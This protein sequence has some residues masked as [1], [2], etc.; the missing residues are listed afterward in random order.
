VIETVDLIPY[1]LPLTRPWRSARGGLGERRGW[2]IRVGSVEL[3]GYGDCAPLP[4]AGTEE[5]AVAWAWL[6][7]WRKRSLRHALGSALDDLAEASPAPGAAW[8]AG[9]APAA[10]NAAECALADLAA[11]R[12]GVPLARWLSAGAVERIPVN[13]AL[14]ALGDIVPADLLASVANGYRVLKVKV[15]LAPPGEE[16]RRLAGL[17]PHIP[18][19]VALRLDANGAWTLGQA[20]RVMAGLAGL[21]ERAMLRVESLEEPLRDPSAPDLRRL[22]AEA[23][24]PLA[25][26]ESLHRPGTDWDPTDLPVRR[27]VLKPAVIGGLRRTMALAA[28]ARAAGP[29]VVLTGLIESAAGLWPTVH[30]AAALGGTIPQGLATAHW[31]SRDLGE[32][33][34]P[35]GGWIDLP[36]GP[37]GGYCPGPDP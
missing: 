8:G 35:D 29:E 34:R 28:R 31:L 15:G 4:A 26:D 30:L 1:R 32:P 24:F 13:A 21:A 25:L 3:W 33:P 19:G 22:Q 27:V 16:L 12:A 5:P 17:V 11:R 7:A 23:A 20:Q 9:P 14:G 36:P 10:R 18:D 6:D 2:L 37:G